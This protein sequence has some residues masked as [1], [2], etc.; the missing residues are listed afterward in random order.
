MGYVSEVRISNNVY[1]VGS[2]LFGICGTAAGTA[3]KTVTLSAFDTLKY[4]V[5]I[6]VQFT[7]ENT[8]AN[9]TMNVN[10][11]GAKP[12]YRYGTTQPIA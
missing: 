2:T 6:H 3:A 1:P 4:G 8:A 9:P 11:T 5:T 7:Y 12:I 10:S